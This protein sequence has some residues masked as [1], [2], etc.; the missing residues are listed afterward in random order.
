MNRPLRLMIYTQ[1]SYGL[2]HLRRT[3]NLANALVSIRKDL[4]ILM[5]VDSPVAPFFELSERIDFVKLPTI[6]KVGAGVFRPDRLAVDYERIKN[7]RSHM[8]LNILQNLQPEIVLVDHMPGGANNE[9]LPALEWART[10]NNNMKFVLGLRDIIDDPKVTCDLWQRENVYETMEKYY[11]AVMI[12][13]A[14]DCFATAEHYKIPHTAKKQI[15]YCG[16]VC[17]KS[18]NKEFNFLKMPGKKQEK[19]RVTVI[20]GGGSD[21]FSLMTTFL[22]SLESNQLETPFNSMIVTGPF[23]PSAHSDLIRKR[24]AKLG[25]A[26][27]KSVEDTMLHVNESDLIVTMAGY[28]TLS[29]ILY[30]QKRALVIPRMGPSREQSLRAAVFASRGLIHTLDPSKCTGP[31]LLEK[32]LEVLGNL[33]IPQKSAIPNMS[34]VENASAIL[35]NL[36]T[37]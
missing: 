4:T 36:L 35:L 5:V 15:H 2:G 12:Y 26:V 11:S 30:L 37:K 34:G 9:L 16:Y 32:I 24:G 31:V 21:A 27:Y 19:P 17:N 25:V 29:E 28:N 13:G 18:V 23:L 10:E 1:D 7:M 22:D 33:E 14:P 6:I 3:T 20:A 8:I